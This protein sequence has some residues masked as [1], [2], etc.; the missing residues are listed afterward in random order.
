MS[1]GDNKIVIYLDVL[2]GVNLFM[3]F[4]VL[5]FVNRICKY[6]ATYLRILGSATC[7]ALWS[8]IAVVIPTEFQW[9]VHICTY[10]LISFLMVKIC[11]GKSEFRD[12]LKGV[13]VLYGVVFVLGGSMHV[14]YYYTY[15]GYWMKQVLLPN[16]SLLLFTAVS[17]ILLYLI[18]AQFLRL[19]VYGGQQCRVELVIAGRTVQLCGF[20]DT[21]NVLMDP[22]CHKPVCVAE[23]KYFQDVLNAINDCTK[24]KYHIVP[25]RSLGCD[26]GLLEVI[27]VDTMYIYNGK[28]KRKISGALVGLT[29]KTLSSDS[30][31]QMLINAQLL[32]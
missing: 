32:L 7:G 3:D 13:L 4:I 15:A 10:V 9:I 22:Y 14:L 5:S 11:A 31:Y 26:D 23:K 20:V 1:G 29:Q 8:V 6:A 30:E 27:S 12:I 16:S 28:R 21:G 17:A 18:L 24:V 25:Y 2:F 19:K